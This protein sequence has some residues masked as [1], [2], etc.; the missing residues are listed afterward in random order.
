[1]SRPVSSFMSMPAVKVLP[2]DWRL[3]VR[4]LL[5]DDLLP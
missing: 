1:M 2:L 4:D 5:L 3:S